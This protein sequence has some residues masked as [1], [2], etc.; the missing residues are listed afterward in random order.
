MAIRIINR[1]YSERYTDGKTDWLLGNVGDWQKLVLDVEVSIDYIATIQN[2]IQIDYLNNSF[3][4][5]NGKTWGDFGFDPGMLLI[6]KYKLSKDTN[7]DGEFDTIENINQQFT[8]QTISGSIMYV[9]EP[10]NGSDF[11][12]VPVNFGTKKISEV[13][14]YVDKESEGCRLFYGHLTNE[15]YKSTS[16]N[17]LIDGSVSEFV[18]SDLSNGGSMEAIGIQ[19]GMSVR[20]IEFT[21]NGKLQNSD[22]IYQYSVEIE[23][24][25]SSLFE[26]ITNFEERKKPSYL[27]KEGSLTDNFIL[28]FYPE[29]NNPN[30]V[31]TNDV[32]KTQRLG[33]TGWFDE[34]F[35]DLN[36]DFKVYSLEYF[37]ED[38]IN[39]ESIDYS[40][41][42]KVKIVISGVPNLDV[43]TECGFG[44][45]WAPTNEEDFK[46]TKTPFYQNLFVQSGSL[47]DGYKLDTA[48]P[49]VYIGAGINGASMDVSGVRFSNLNG[50]IVFEAD[51]IPNSNFSSLFD[52]K[53]ETDRK[54]ILFVSVADGSLTRNK[55][56]RV[57]LLTDYNDLIKTIPQVGEY[58]FLT[59]KFIEHPGADNAKGEL[60]YEGIVQDDILCRMPF[61]LKKDGSSVFEK[62]TFGIEAFN[63][64][65]D[66]SFVLEKYEIDLSNSPI[67]S[68]GIQQFNFDETRG[69]KLESGNNKNLVKIKRETGSDTPELNGYIAYFA[70]KIR[71]EDWILNQDAPSEFFDSSLL[72]NGLN[73]DWVG[74]LNK[75]GWVINF[76]TEINSTEEDEL[77]QYKNQF[78]FT[79]KDYDQN[80]NI[81]T[82][83]KYKKDSDNSILNIGTDPET[84]KPLGVILSSEPTRIEI[85][86]DIQDAGVWDLPNTYAVTTI[87]IDKGAGR[88]EQ[89]QLSS[90]WGSEDDNPLK[91]V[92]GET[93]LKMTVDGTGKIL[94]TFCLV[95]PTLLDKGTRY[96]VT[97]R[98]GCYDQEGVF[99]PGI[100]EYIYEDL[101]E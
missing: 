101:Y 1:K 72:N 13:K 3:V 21:N 71:W 29:W 19:S 25:I 17:S 64:G 31:I 38:G 36:N 11:D 86:F 23:F 65:T 32:T 87:E 57:S 10:I 67:D 97:G 83:H 33:N 59:N 35:N 91:P 20:K 24:M 90:V 22:N 16:L 89:R 2:P 46:D 95:D 41:K 74:Y 48:Y 6:F 92:S 61:S 69:F 51:F 45:S 96:R 4:L 34:N 99:V 77:V 47:E 78:K 63:V 94:T 68:N 26:D 85:A 8:I 54:Y 5:N 79:F 37:N 53:E 9:A 43:N 73:N 7:G 75:I 93:K 62:M 14:F 49:N 28:S 60:V 18:L 98:V 80:E 82:D 55:S 58:E 76:F 84:G 100:Y 39:V 88:F 40:S 44:F 50:L 70:T 12:N 81:N 42:T 56:D 66:Q 52:Q 15:N 27:T 30:V